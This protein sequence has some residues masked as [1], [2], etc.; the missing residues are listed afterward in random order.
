M[1]KKNKFEISV[2]LPSYNESENIREALERL[3]R[4]LGKNLYEIIVVDD[5]SPDET[6]RV[7]QD[8]KNPKYKVI[9]RM[10]EKGLA[11]A[12]AKGVCEAK[13]NI[14]VWMDA[15]LGIPPEIALQLVEK[16]H[17]Y[18]VAIGSRYI[19]GGGDPRPF[20]LPFLSICL[21]T[22]AR[23]LF[24]PQIRDYTSG[25]VAVRKSIIDKTL[26]KDTG[27][28]EYFAEFSYR[29]IKQNVRIIE[30]PLQYQIRKNG[31]SKISGGSIW[32]LL[33]Y[34]IQYGLKMI[35]WRLTIR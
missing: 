25:V 19:T 31:V 4:S 34:G 11:S 8:V 7:V 12:I 32:V 33:R 13:G 27:F 26:W 2:I 22:Y 23:L 17:D 5:N 24:G 18:D 9:R 15:D 30:V 20:P 10:N 29:C 14:I 21:N 16:L 3:S 1:K 35:K 28:G 6:W